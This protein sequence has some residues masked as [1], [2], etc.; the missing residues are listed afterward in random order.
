M[1]TKTFFELPI[2]A[3]KT[4]V[5]IFFLVSWWWGVKKVKLTTESRRWDDRDQKKVN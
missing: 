1:K 3:V 2:E 4:R 5:T